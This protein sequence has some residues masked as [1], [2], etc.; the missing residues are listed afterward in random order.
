M[1][2]SGIRFLQ[3]YKN[4]QRRQ[5]LE[6]FCQFLYSKNNKA[7]PPIVGQDGGCRDRS[8]VRGAAGH[9]G[10]EEPDQDRQDRAR[11][12]AGQG[13]ISQNSASAENFSDSIFIHKFWTIFHPKKTDIYT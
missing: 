8:P 13:S 5:F 4:I 6:I 11:P 2:I 3:L 12:E 9:E 1:N 7:M 10:A